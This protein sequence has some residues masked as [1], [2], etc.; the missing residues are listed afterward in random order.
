[1]DSYE[2]RL[3]LLKLAQ[4]I[5]QNNSYNTQTKLQQDWERNCFAVEERNSTRKG[6]VGVDELE[7]YPDYPH[8]S[9]IT[10]KEVVYIAQELNAFVVSNG[11]N[12]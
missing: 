6:I 5:L 7:T 9:N 1:M 12:K 11:I 10:A 8:L 3:E 2:I 4:T